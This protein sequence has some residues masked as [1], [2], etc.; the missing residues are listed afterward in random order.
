[1]SQLAQELGVSVRTIRRDIATP[2]APVWVLLCEAALV[3]EDAFFRLIGRMGQARERM[4]AARRVWEKAWNL[5]EEFQSL[6][7]VQALAVAF[8]A[9][10]STKEPAYEEG[11]QELAGAAGG[12]VSVAVGSVGAG[13]VA[14]APGGAVGGGVGLGCSVPCG[15]GKAIRYSPCFRVSAAASI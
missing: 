10:D 11:L 2:E 14:S 8:A 5:H 12:E 6:E 9:W 13:T 1:M 7:T 15:V 4:H 3:S